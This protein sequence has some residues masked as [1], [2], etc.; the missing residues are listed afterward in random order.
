M[1]AVERSDAGQAHAEGRAARLTAEAVD[2]DAVRYRTVEFATGVAPPPD[3]PLT[4]AQ[5]QML[6][7]IEAMSPVTESLN[8]RFSLSPPA[9]TTEEAVIRGLRHLIQDHEALRARYVP[10]PEGHGQRVASA[11]RLEVAIARLRD[12]DAADRAVAPAVA[13]LASHPFDISAELPLRVAVLTVGAEARHIVFA[14]CHLMVDGAGAIRFKRQLRSLLGVEPTVPATRSPGV[15]QPREV[16]DWERSPTGVRNAAR[17]VEQ[18]AQTMSAMPQTML[19]RHAAVTRPPRYRY[20][21]L[22]SPALA[23][24]VPALAARHRTTP[25]TVLY[26]GLAAVSSFVS[27]LPRAFLQ[28]PVGNRV[29]PRLADA[30]AMLAQVVPVCV[31]TADAT[32]A[33]VIARSTGAVLKAAR[34][35]R[36]P[37]AALAEARRRIELSRGVAFDLSCWLNYMPTARLAPSTEVP[38]ASLLGQARSRTRWRWI[39]GADNSTSTYFV[40]ANGSPASLTLTAIIDTAL[41]PEAEAVGWLRAIERVLCDSLHGDVAVAEIGAHTGLA[42]AAYGPDWC[43]THAGWIHR[44]DV[45]ELVRRASGV[46]RV[47]VFAT[48]AAEGPRL[49]ALLDGADSLRDLEGLHADC[50]AAL[51]GQRTAAAPDHY[52]VCAGAPRTT[53]LTGWR[54]LRVVVEG[55]GRP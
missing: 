5:E 4:W 41:L 50:V 47:G 48:P 44:P 13:A 46:S 33:D 18:H 37:P 35:G 45:A 1:S 39:E 28:L 3:I 38:S 31:E 21:E 42:S 27:G 10:V 9:G 34:F 55:S 14:M 52:V 23:M 26:A 54:R 40:F 7:L 8:L 32:V 17:A 19:P 6:E 30:V 2:A 24:A 53:D 43:L 29:E 22:T 12:G 20:L 49:V 25:A 11:G 16:A 51:A 15:V 36:Y